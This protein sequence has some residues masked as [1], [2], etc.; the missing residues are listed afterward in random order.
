[1]IVGPDADGRRLESAEVVGQELGADQDRVVVG[2][3]E[4]VG[5]EQGLDMV[6][7]LEVG[8]VVEHDRLVR[9]D[10][11]LGRPGDLGRQR[12]VGQRVVQVAGLALEDER[13]RVLAQEGPD[14][15][16]V[17]GRLEDPDRIFLRVAV[18]IADDD[19]VLVAASGRVAGDP[20]DQGLCGGDAGLVA[21]ALAV[22][23]VRVA[24]R[25]ASPWT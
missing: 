11:P 1:M 6:L 7:R 16:L 18:E 9:V 12:C 17:A 14:H 23:G 24:D 5:G 25:R 21:V 2:R 22:T 15:V 20:V 3:A 19:G 4:G 10:V 8:V 13:V